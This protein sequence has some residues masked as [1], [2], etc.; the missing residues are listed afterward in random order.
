MYPYI[1]LL[2]LLL[3]ILLVCVPSFLCADAPAT[4]RISRVYQI[5]AA[6]ICASAILHGV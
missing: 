1:L 5:V 4:H 6:Y 2:L 3:R